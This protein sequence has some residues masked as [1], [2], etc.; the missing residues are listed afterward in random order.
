MLAQ[1]TWQRKSDCK[2]NYEPE[3]KKS[4]HFVSPINLIIAII[5]NYRFSVERSFLEFT[6]IIFIFFFN[7]N[8]APTLSL[9]ILKKSFA[10]VPFASLSS[11]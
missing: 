7:F 6:V 2:Y 9:E 4:K 5:I 10:F 11:C 3:K 8:S 1:F